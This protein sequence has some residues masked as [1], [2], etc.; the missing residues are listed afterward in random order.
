MKHHNVSF[1]GTFE[2]IRAGDNLISIAKHG[3]ISP[4]W[5]IPSPKMILQD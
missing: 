5:Q 2:S 3:F 1:S 4:H